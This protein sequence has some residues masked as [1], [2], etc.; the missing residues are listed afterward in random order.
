MIYAKDGNII[1]DEKSIQTFSGQI[2]KDKDK[3]NI[4]EFDEIDFNLAIFP[5]ILF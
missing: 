5:L 2:N 3:I 4:F 1:E